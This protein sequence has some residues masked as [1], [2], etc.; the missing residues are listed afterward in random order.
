MGGATAPVAMAMDRIS[1]SLRLA[2]FVCC[3]VTTTFF[4]VSSS[5]ASIFFRQI[6]AFVV[7]T[8]RDK[9]RARRPPPP[10]TTTAKN[11]LC[12]LRLF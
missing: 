1:Q 11:M 12:A 6:Y 10:P 4:Y 8:F 2:F 3:S 9:V 7:H 5:S